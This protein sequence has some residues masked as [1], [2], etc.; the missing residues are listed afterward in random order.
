MI[1]YLQYITG[2]GVP[3]SSRG[4]GC[5]DEEAL[6]MGKDESKNVFSMFLEGEPSSLQAVVVSHLPD[7][8]GPTGSGSNFAA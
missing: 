5:G 3:E 7:V 1:E 4:T 6:I 8:N 2:C